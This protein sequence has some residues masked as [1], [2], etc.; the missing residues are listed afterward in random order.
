MSK[1]CSDPI[2]CKLGFDD[3]AG[4]DDN[5]VPNDIMMLQIL[6]IAEILSVA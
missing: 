3:G 5:F 4:E 6:F 1:Y 2:I